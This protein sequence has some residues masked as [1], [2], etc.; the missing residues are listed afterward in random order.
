MPRHAASPANPKPLQAL[1]RQARDADI[2]TAAGHPSGAAL[3]ALRHEAARCRACPL[4]KL[5]TQ[6]VFGEG[7]PGAPI[8]LVG[9]QPGDKEDLAGRPF[10]G[11]AGALLDRALAAAGIAREAVYVTNA[12]KHFKW[13]PGLRGKRR[14]HKTPAQ[15]EIEACN[16]WLQA[17][18]QAVAP[19][20]VVALGA[21]A[22]R[23]LLRRATPVEANRG[24][25]MHF[26]QRQLLIT[27]HPSAL[28]RMPA[29]SRDQAYRRFVADLALARPYLRRLSD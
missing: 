15:K 23:A 28:L 9:E 10:V 1:H 29:A 21:T 2:D 19:R 24:R 6:T 3:R 13:E 25:V 7:A 11:P 8:M 4:W 17:E 27:T 20:L 18:L 14:M 26:A 22:A 12:V 16:R 5:G